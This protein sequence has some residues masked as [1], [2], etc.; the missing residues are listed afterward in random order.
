MASFANSPPTA[1]KPAPC[2]AACGL[3]QAAHDEECSVDRAR[4]SE[5]R[6]FKFHTMLLHCNRA[7]L[8]RSYFVQTLLS[9]IVPAGWLHSLV[10]GAGA[11]PPLVHGHYRAAAAKLV[12]CCAVVHLPNAQ[13]RQCPCTHDAGLHCDIQL[14]PARHH[15]PGKSGMEEP[16]G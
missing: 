8:S 6:P 1:G 5:V 10:M 16:M 7:V 14:A 9:D 13:Q 15:T 12:I 11:A 4:S 2:A 3:L